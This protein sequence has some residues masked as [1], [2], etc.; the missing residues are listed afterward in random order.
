MIRSI[1]DILAQPPPQGASIF[2]RR[3]DER[4]FETMAHSAKCARVAASNQ[5]LLMGLILLLILS[6]RFVL[7]FFPGCLER[8]VNDSQH[9]RFRKVLGVPGS[10]SRGQAISKE[11]FGQGNEL[12]RSS[13]GRLVPPGMVN[14]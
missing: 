1:R 3:T 5:L 14:F 7:S 2:L 6:L 10:W 9:L 12:L 8:I 11:R 4:P 13:H